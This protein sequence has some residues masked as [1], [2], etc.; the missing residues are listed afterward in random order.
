[1]TIALLY[2]STPKQLTETLRQVPLS[3]FVKSLLS[4]ESDTGA[5][6][7]GLIVSELLL[8]KVAGTFVEHYMKEGTSEALRKLA[9]HAPPSAA[10]QAPPL[11]V[12]RARTAGSPVPD[13]PLMPC[14]S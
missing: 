10:A 4:D 12:R 1:M 3:V 5:P 13:E 7:A 8:S 14:R 6:A 11:Q 9:Q 2:L